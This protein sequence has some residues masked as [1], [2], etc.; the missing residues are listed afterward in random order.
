MKIP[1]KMTVIEITEYGNAE[2]L[3]PANR[4]IEMPSADEVL[5]EV[6]ATGVNRPDVMQRQGMYPPPP[7]A[8]DIPGLEISGKIVATGSNVTHLNI[9]DSVCA[10]VTGGGYGQYCLAA[11]S[12]C[13]P[14]PTGLT[15]LQAAALPETFFTVWSNLFDRG[16]L[17]PGETLLIHG[18]TSGIGTTAIQLAIFNGATVIVTTGSDEKC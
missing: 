6:A 10:L 15:L 3:K 18:G 4:K 13:L 1:K 16:N 17:V 7:G 14:V 2:V 9:G 11:A 5:V 8:S 12:L